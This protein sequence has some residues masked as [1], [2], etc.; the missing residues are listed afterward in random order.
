MPLLRFNL[1]E[2]DATGVLPSDLHYAE[3]D[4]RKIQVAKKAKSDKRNAKA[5]KK[6]A[7]EQ[8]AKLAETGKPKATPP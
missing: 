3:A 2:T 5:R 8:K 4:E 1:T 6:R 7:Q